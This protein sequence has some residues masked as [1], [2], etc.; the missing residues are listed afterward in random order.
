MNWT[1]LKLSGPA[2]IPANTIGISGNGQTILA[3]EH[4]VDGGHIHISNNQGTSWTERDPAGT[5]KTW[6]AVASNSDGTKLIAGVYNGRLYTS[7][8]GGANWTERQPAGAVNKFWNRAA[9]SSNGSILIVCVYGG[10]LYTSSDSGVNWT[11]RQ[12]AGAVNKNWNSVNINRNGTIMIACV[13]G[14]R[15]Y[16]STDSGV[17][18][19]EVQPIGNNDGL[20]TD[21]TISDDGTKIAVCAAL[22]VNGGRIYH[23]TD[24]GSNWSEWQPAGDTDKDWYHISMNNTGTQIIAGS[25]GG[26]LYSSMNSGSTWSEERPEGDIDADWEVVL[27]KNGDVFLASNASRLYIATP[28]VPLVPSKATHFEIQKSSNGSSWITIAL[29][30]AT[31]TTYTLNYHEGDKTY[32]FRV[33]AVISHIQQTAGL[34]W[35]SDWSNV[36]NANCTYTG[37]ETSFKVERKRDDEG[38]FTEIAS[39]PPNTTTYTDTDL[40]LEHDYSYRVRGYNDSGYSD[41]TNI[42]TFD[43]YV[44]KI[45]NWA[46]SKIGD[47]PIWCIYGA[48]ERSLAA[49]EIYFILRRQML[50]DFEWNFALK[51]ASL[52]LDGSAPEFEFP[53]RFALPPD[54]M[55]V[56]K[57][58]DHLKKWRIENGYLLSDSNVIKILYVMNDEST[59]LYDSIFRDC[60]ATK[61]A[62]ELALPL[63]G[64]KDLVKFLWDLYF[65]KILEARETT[66]LEIGERVKNFTFPKRALSQDQG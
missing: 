30:L 26:R 45:I 34:P 2:E 59:L 22:G 61:L 50:R 25:F 1:E 41:Y 40:V 21:V 18:W 63:T 64:Q 4:T 51:R 48:E 42:A 33:R 14:G 10:R 58:H 16:V 47:D 55:Y 5:A 35:Y 46:L 65:E 37:E 9:S 36:P 31:A 29:I 62:A 12:P 43:H 3:G 15:I 52:T 11:E 8:N 7:S 13:W 38:G 23:S 57:I 32:Y 17:N 39:L 49:R 19:S 56:I 20:W 6:G 28:L 44:E 66:G 53:Y 24:S 54:C 27:N 60:L